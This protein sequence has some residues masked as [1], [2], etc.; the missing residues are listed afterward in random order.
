ME[1]DAFAAFVRDDDRL[2]ALLGV[3]APVGTIA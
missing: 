1:A 2:A 3:R